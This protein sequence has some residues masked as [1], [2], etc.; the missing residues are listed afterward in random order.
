VPVD[1]DFFQ[2]IND[3]QMLWYQIQMALDEE[4]QFELL[5]DVAEHNAMFTN[6]EG[7]QQVRDSRENTYETPE[8]DFHDI[9]KDTFG[10]DIPEI[11]EQERI[12]FGEVLKQQRQEHKAKP[13]V[14][15]EL[16]EISFIPLK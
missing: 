14:E 12:P 6:P 3:A 10:R 8:E 9:L 16:D 11:P 1:H 15:M 13:Y 2:K 7:V 5:R 4:E